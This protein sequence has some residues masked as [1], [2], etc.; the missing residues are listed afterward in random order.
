MGISA[1][2][3]LFLAVLAGIAWLQFKLIAYLRKSPVRYLIAGHRAL[4][5]DKCV[6]V[7]SA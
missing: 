7:C 5:Y 3:A 4:I 6:D 2:A 1:A